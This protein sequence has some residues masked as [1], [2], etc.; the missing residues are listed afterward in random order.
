MPMSGKINYHISFTFMGTER[1]ADVF[2]FINDPKGTVYSQSDGQEC[3]WLNYTSEC[4]WVVQGRTIYANP[5]I[6]DFSAWDYKFLEPDDVD[7]AWKKARVK[8]AKFLK[9]RGWARE[10]VY[11]SRAEGIG[12]QWFKGEKRFLTAKEAYELERSCGVA[13]P[14]VN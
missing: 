14:S 1:K 13:T 12:S 6:K 2:R 5:E 3:P 9:Q 8:R 11:N 10:T 7:A 4:G